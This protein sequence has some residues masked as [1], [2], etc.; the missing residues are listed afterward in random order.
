[1]LESFEKLVDMADLLSI[2]LVGSYL[3]LDAGFDSQA[4][5][6]MVAFQEIIPVIR[7]NIRNTKDEK[8]KE[9]LFAEFNKEVYM[10]RITI[11]R[12]FA[13][14]DTY[15]KLVIR[16]ER[17]QATHLGFKHLAYAMINYRTIFGRK[18]A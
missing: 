7:P 14:Q 16:Y 3:T 15:R 11:E 2:D 13:W 8:K 4:N 5:K 6:T 1:M 9:L 18:G 17:L 12:C 10:K